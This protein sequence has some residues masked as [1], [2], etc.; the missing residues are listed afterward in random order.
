MS[1]PER[2]TSIKCTVCGRETEATDA[3]CPSCGKQLIKKLNP[4]KLTQGDYNAV[5]STTDYWKC[6]YCGAVSPDVDKVCHHCKAV[7]KE[8][9]RKTESQGEAPVEWTR[10]KG[11]THKRSDIVN[12]ISARLGSLTSTGVEYFKGLPR[13]Y[14]LVALGIL[15]VIIGALPLWNA[16]GLNTV[17]SV[18]LLAGLGLILVTGGFFKKKS[19]GGSTS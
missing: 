5:R 11:E 15:L 9:P 18:L 13:N 3:H 10:E 16:I 4:I 14:Q 17:G 2:S 1:P 12:S 8:T 6:S 19:K 7:R